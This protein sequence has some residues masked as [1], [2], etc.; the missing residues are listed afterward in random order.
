[1]EDI[2]STRVPELLPGEEVPFGK[3]AGAM[4]RG[5]CQ[6]AGAMRALV[7]TIVAVGSIDTLLAAAETLQ[8]V[9]DAG[10][11]RGILISEGDNPAPPARVAGNTV[12]LEGL[13]ALY[14]NNAVA[15]L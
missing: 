15:A 9:G 11:V 7:A 12:S 14:V 5:A 4:A 6:D 10:T 2:V 3:I 1:M 13:K 8:R